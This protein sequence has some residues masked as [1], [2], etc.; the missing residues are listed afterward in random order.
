[1]KIRRTKKKKSGRWEGNGK[2][3][4]TVRAMLSL[5]EWLGYTYAV[6]IL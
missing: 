4:K 5:A 6:L 3:K 1:M 2:K